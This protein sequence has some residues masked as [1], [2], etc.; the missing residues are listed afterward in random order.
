MSW[1]KLGKTTSETAAILGIGTFMVKSH[2]RNIFKKLHAHNR[3][4]AVSRVEQ[5]PP[6]DA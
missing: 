2:L 3:T 1:T 4:L 5:T 6:G